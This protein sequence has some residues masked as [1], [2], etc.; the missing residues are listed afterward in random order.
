VNS[1]TRISLNSIN[2][3]IFVMM[4]CC[5]LFE[6]RPEFLN[7]GHCYLQEL[8]L[9]RVNS[10][11]RQTKEEKEK[12]RKENKTDEMRRKGTDLRYVIA[13]CFRTAHSNTHVLRY[14]YI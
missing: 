12:R 2:Q 13:Y 4:N 3:F 5:V 10:S 9:Q 7:L 6:V 8:R 14:K 11:R 1:D